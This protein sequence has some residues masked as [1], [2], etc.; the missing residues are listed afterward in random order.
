MSIKSLGHL[1]GLMCNMNSK[2]LFI[3]TFQCKWN[4]AAQSMNSVKSWRNKNYEDN[5]KDKTLCVIEQLCG[6]QTQRH[7]AMNYNITKGNGR[8]EAMNALITGS[9]H[10]YGKKHGFKKI[11]KAEL[12]TRHRR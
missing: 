9:G 4:C 12:D 2:I 10:N 6:S 3:A 7:T 5:V 1:M 11:R 8:T